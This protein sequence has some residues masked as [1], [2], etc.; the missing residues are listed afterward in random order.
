MFCM[1]F[2]HRMFVK[3]GPHNILQKG[4]HNILQKGPHNIIQKGP[5]NIPK[6]YNNITIAHRNNKKNNT[7]L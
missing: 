3:K 6:G 5:H 1:F 7:I 4:P 2:L